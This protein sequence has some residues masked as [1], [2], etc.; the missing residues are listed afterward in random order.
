M[1]CLQRW[2][3][4][5]EWTQAPLPNERPSWSDPTHAPCSP[6]GSFQLPPPSTVY[7]SATRKRTFT[8]K[9]S[10][11]EWRIRG[12]AG[13]LISPSTIGANP[14]PVN[15]SNSSG[16]ASGTAAATAASMS[17]KAAKDLK[18][19]MG[20]LGDWK[21]KLSSRR[22][23]EDKERRNSSD[24]K[25]NNANSNHARKGSAS[26]FGD[27]F[28]ALVGAKDEKSPVA[29]AQDGKGRFSSSAIIDD[30]ASSSNA[31]IELDPGD[32][33][34]LLG[35]PTRI[36]DITIATSDPEAKTWEVD[37]QG[38][39][40]TDNQ[41]EKPTSKGGM[42]RYTR[43]RAWVRRAVVVEK[44]EDVN[45]DDEVE[46]EQAISAAARLGLSTKLVGVKRSQ[47]RESKKEK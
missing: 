38:W 25:G 4:G 22:D 21:Q 15:T 35:H 11:P 39:V 46:R 13:V 37:A 12:T 9:W 34:D 26:F 3:I 42:G 23:T 24:E 19:A 17:E 31:V 32:N 28:N 6:P 41:W 44:V 43:R 27:S 36:D 1:I 47:S 5:L 14:N 33:P 45:L 18:D 8:W 29:P 16:V 10:D 7:I 30:E 20:S 2:W 40:Y